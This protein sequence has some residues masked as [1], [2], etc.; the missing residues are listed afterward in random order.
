MAA[1]QA[2]QVFPGIEARYRVTVQV[3]DVHHSTQKTRPGL[4]AGGAGRLPAG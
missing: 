3:E 4:R 1:G 2:V